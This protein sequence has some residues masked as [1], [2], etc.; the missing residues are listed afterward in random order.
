MAAADLGP[1]SKYDLSQFKWTFPDADR[2]ERL[3]GG[4]EYIEH[5]WNHYDRGD[6]NIFAAIYVDIK[7]PVSNV[8]LKAAARET[9]AW[10]RFHIPTL[11]STTMFNED[12]NGIL[13]YRK[14]K[15]QSSVDD[16]AKRTLIEEIA[17]PIDLD[18]LRVRLGPKVLPDQNGD[19]TWLHLVTTGSESV[20]KFG[21]LVHSHHTPFDGAGLKKT[22]NR[23][24]RRL[25][26]RLYSPDL[27]A[28]TLK[29]GSEISNLNP[30]CFEILNSSNSFPVPPSSSADPQ[31]TD[32]YYAYLV[33][34]MT[35]LSKDAQV[36]LI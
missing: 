32:P 29:W 21:L 23:Y 22:L 6:Q 20:N 15:S 12:N 7:S 13:V 14:A 34:F 24:L 9:W 5:I 36:L 4:A 26:E 33:D 11:A 1:L 25:A 19:Q 8:V 2:A 27:P 28:E 10:L 31:I 35:K 16:W 18:E 30:C 17:D 3:I